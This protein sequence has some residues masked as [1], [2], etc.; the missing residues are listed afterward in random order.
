MKSENT[1][2]PEIEFDVALRSYWAAESNT[3]A[4]THG[5]R[6]FSMLTL[7][8]QVRV[9]NDIRHCEVT[10]KVFEL[11]LTQPGRGQWRT[12][13]GFNP[14]NSEVLTNLSRIFSSVE[15]T[16]ATT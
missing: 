7:Q 4:D 6:Q 13:G 9:R 5:L 3:T 11:Q 16:S 15:N 2:S 1:A 12:E 10:M 14:P 8:K